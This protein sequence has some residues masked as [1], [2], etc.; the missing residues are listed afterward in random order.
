MVQNLT[1]HYSYVSTTRQKPNG[2]FVHTFIDLSQVDKNI[3]K[4]IRQLTQYLQQE[5]PTNFSKSQP[6]QEFS[7][8]FSVKASEDG[9]QKTSIC[10]SNI[11]APPEE[12][13]ALHKLIKEHGRSQKS[14][15]FLPDYGF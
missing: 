1:A 6:R 12:Y 14:D 11:L 3:A 9:E 2:E 4:D 10:A 8:F 5:A 15:N 7:R 13:I